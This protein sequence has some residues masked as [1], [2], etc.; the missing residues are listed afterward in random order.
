MFK[1]EEMKPIPQEVIDRFP[2]NSNG[3]FNPFNIDAFSM[4]QKFCKDIYYMCSQ[5]NDQDYQSGHFVNI[6]SGERQ[7]LVAIE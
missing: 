5:H 1:L 7:K 3:T 4:G 2:K 6:R